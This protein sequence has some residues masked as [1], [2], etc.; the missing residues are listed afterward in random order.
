MNLIFNVTN[1]CNFKCSYCFV[2]KSTE[3]MKFNTMIDFIELYKNK[4]NR[5]SFFGGEPFLEYNNIYKC[6]EYCKKNNYKF[7]YS[8]N[9]N[10][11]I[12]DDEKILFLKENEFSVTISLDGIKKSHDLNRRFINGD[13]TYN[14]V[15]ENLKKLEKNNINYFINYVIAPNNICYFSKS[16]KY[17][18]ENDINKINL[19]IQRDAVW[20][21]EDVK[22]LRSEFFIAIDYLTKLNFKKN[23]L[24]IIQIE[25]KNRVLLNNNL[26]RKCDFGKE[27]VYIDIDG[28]KKS[29]LYFLGKKDANIED[30][31][32]Y[33]K[34]I[35]KNRKCETCSYQKFCSNNCVCANRRL[36][37]NSKVDIVCESEKI[38]IDVAREVNKQLFNKI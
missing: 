26:L 7:N 5:I 18:F 14:L 34:E 9:T 15:Y 2:K 13:E 35:E 19:L 23:K 25:N 31:I 1:N 6:V 20:R 27:D 4:I 38:F 22:K 12:L 3:C 16:I 33:I 11:S 30:E 32:N 17:F 8:I 37:A 36:N 24:S 21:E 10:L 28:K 29:C